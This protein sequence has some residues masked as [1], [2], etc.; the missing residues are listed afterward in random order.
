M[1]TFDDLIPRRETNSLKWNHGRRLLTQK[2]S[3]ADPLPMWVADMD[4]RVAPFIAEALRREIDKS[5]LGYGGTPSSYLD[6][7]LAWQER[8]FGWLADE[9]WIVRTPGVISALNVALQAFTR[10]GDYVLVQPPVYHHFLKD[11]IANG[12][13][14]ALAPLETNAQGRYYFDPERF[15]AAICPG[16]RLFILCNPHNPTGNVWSRE[17]LL[18]MASICQRHGIL[19]VSDEIHQDLVFDRTKRHIPF[20]MLDHPAAVDSIVCTAPTKT[21]NIAGLQCA[22]I[23]VP[24]PRLRDAF[25]NQLERNGN[26]HPNTLGTAACEAAYRDGAAWVDA[27]LTYVGKN[28]ALF[29][30]R[31]REMGLPIRVTPAEALYLAWIDCRSLRLPQLELFD[32]FACRSRLWLDPGSKFGTAGE[33]FMR[34]NLACPRLLVDEALLRLEHSLLI[35]TQK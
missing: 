3:A 8:R 6:A 34:I 22:N 7:V 24:N 14:L 18:E 4:F 28:Q 21:F 17:E 10:E 5:A 19:I 11:V 32:F 9:A 2:Q 26:S 1:H 33:G 29:A 30:G 23:F 15:E 25:K 13:R 31:V 35:S 27:M 16:T 20:A 12:R